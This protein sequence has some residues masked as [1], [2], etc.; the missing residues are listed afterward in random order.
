[1]IDLSDIGNVNKLIK[2]CIES[3]RKSQQTFYQAFYGKMLSVCMRYADNREEAKD[4]LHDGFIKVFASLNDFEF[5]GSLEG[6]IRK[7]VTNTAIDTVRK[8]KNFIV[9]LE[10]NRNYDHFFDDNLETKE[11][12]EFVTLKAETMMLLIQKLSP[13]YRTVFNLYVFEDLSHKEIAEQLNI[14]IGTSKSNYAKAKK[15]LIKLF[16][17]YTNEHQQ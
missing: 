3:D 5:K 14:N 12:Q 17:D 10:E 6:W 9:E 2:G 8:K 13:M 11:Q 1:M 16:E 4:M 7:I 15:N